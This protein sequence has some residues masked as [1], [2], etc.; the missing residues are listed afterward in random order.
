MMLLTKDHY[1]QLKDGVFDETSKQ[2]LDHLFEALAAD[3]HQDHIVLNFHGGLV[4]VEH[5]RET[6]ENLMQ[7]FQNVNTYQIFVIW[8]TSVPEVIDQ[9]GGVFSFVEAQLLQI[10]KEGIFQQLLMQV[11]QFA[12]AKVASVQAGGVRAVGGGLDLPDEDDVWQ[13]MHTPEDG[14]EPFAN[15]QPAL[16]AHEQL[17]DEEREQFFQTLT[18]NP[19]LQ[20]EVQKVV[21]GYRQAGQADASSPQGMARG[22]EGGESGETAPTLISPD[23]MEQMTQQEDQASRGI[24]GSAIEFVAGKA[25]EVLSHVI[26]RFAQKTDHGLYPTVVE[27]ILRAFYLASIGKHVWDHIKQEVT[28]AFNQPDHG[29]SLFLKKLQAYYQDGHHPQITL[30]GHSAGAIYV[31][32]LLQ[33]IKKILPEDVT[34]NVVS[35]APACTYKLFADTLKAC[36]ERIAAIRIFAMDDQR[37][38]ADVIVPNIYTRSLLYLVSGVFE[39]VADTPILGMERFFKTQ[40]LVNRWSEIPQILEYLNTSQRNNVWSI[41]DGG[42]G[43]SSHAEHHGDFYRETFTLTSLEY[44]LTNGLG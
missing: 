34:F 32:Q 29:G 14:R 17:Q 12:R 37:E 38:Q 6:A 28:D 44:I 24:G 21:N 16:P 33:Q 31:C 3:P 13:E 19:D 9:E 10:A 25:I 26:D 20:D 23:V 11:L 41:V 42:D 36:Q 15:V 43:L 2:D 40:A 1:I 4:S 18:T 39:E 7:R 30:V 27:E 22:I 8:E 35:L 5:A